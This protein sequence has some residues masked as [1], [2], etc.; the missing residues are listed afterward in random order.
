MQPAATDSLTVEVY[1]DIICPWCYIGKRRFTEALTLANLSDDDVRVIWRPFDLNPTMPPNGMDRRDYR[2]KKFGS[3]EY[4]QRLDQQVKDAGEL[5][6]LQ[7]NFERMQRAPN[8]RK[9]H[10][11]LEFA[12][13]VENQ[14]ALAE[15]LFKAYF[16]DGLDIGDGPTLVKIAESIGI[17]RTKAEEILMDPALEQRLMQDFDRARSLGVQSVPTFVINNTMMPAGAQDPYTI[18]DAL[19]TGLPV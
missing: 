6:G 2:I 19:R 18:A 1:S 7:F 8:T 16:S 11:L 17:K 5:V 12:I 3:W 15:A 10:L 9:A 13:T 14:N 4:S